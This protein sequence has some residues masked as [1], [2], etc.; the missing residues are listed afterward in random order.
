MAAA[1]QWRQ[2][3]N[4]GSTSQAH[5]V[6]R[7]SLQTSWCKDV[8]FSTSSRPKRLTRASPCACDTTAFSSSTAL[9][10]SCRLKLGPMK[11]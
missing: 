9:C 5:L 8:T 11:P 2:H 1:W 10:T 3:G 7:I 6:N 4:G